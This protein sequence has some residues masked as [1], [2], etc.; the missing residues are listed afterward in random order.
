LYIPIHIFCD[1][2][3]DICILNRESVH[4]LG[5]NNINGDAHS[6]MRDSRWRRAPGLRSIAASVGCGSWRCFERRPVV[7]QQQL[8]SATRGGGVCSSCPGEPMLRAVATSATRGDGVCYNEGMRLLQDSAS[9][10]RGGLCVASAFATIG[11]GNCYK[12]GGY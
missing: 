1:L 3:I 9:S 7:L 6:W 2:R 8:A 10:R 4:R 5:N 12:G 11:G